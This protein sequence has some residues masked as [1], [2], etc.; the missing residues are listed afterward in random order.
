MIAV[1]GGSTVL[2][3]L[4]NK[5]LGHKRF[6]VRVQ[7]TIQTDK[8]RKTVLNWISDFGLIFGSS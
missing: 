6:K 4:G 1:L 5:K 2:L 7:A 3:L 8:C